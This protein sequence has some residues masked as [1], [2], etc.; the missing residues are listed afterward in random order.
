MVKKNQGM[1]PLLLW[2]RMTLCLYLLILLPPRLQGSGELLRC[3][4]PA[5]SGRNPLEGREIKPL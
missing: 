4:T 5:S 3:V 1:Y 2:Y